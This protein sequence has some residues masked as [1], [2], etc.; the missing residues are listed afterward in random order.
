L[1]T[2]YSRHYNNNSYLITM[3]SKKSNLPSGFKC[4]GN[5]KEGHNCQIY[6]VA[7]SDDL[8]QQHSG[9]AD[10]PL[11]Q[12]FATCGGNTVSVY[13]VHDRQKPRIVLRQGYI[14]AHDDEVFYACAFGGRSL[15]RPFGYGPVNNTNDEKPGDVIVLGSTDE[16]DQDR[17]R[18]REEEEPSSTATPTASSSK[19]TT[20]KQTKSSGATMDTDKL[21]QDMIDTDQ[22]DGPQLLCV[23][24][25]GATVK[26]I[27]VCRRMLYTTLSGHGDDIYDLKFS[28][29][30]EWIL[31]SASKDE[32]LRMWNIKTSTC[33]AIFS[34]HEGHRDCVLSVAWHPHGNKFASGGMDTTVKLWDVGE[35]GSSGVRD[36]IARSKTVKP[37]RLDQRVDPESKFLLIYEQMPIFSTDKVHT[38]YVDGIQFVGDLILSKDTNDKVLLWKPVT[39]K[40]SRGSN[41][42]TQQRLPNE[43]IVLREFTLSK[44]DVWFVRFATDHKCRMLALGNNAGEIKVW[45]IRSRPSD[46]H[47][48]NL[49]HQY[50]SSAVRM[51]AFNHDDKYLV[52]VTD[53][54]SVLLW[55]ATMKK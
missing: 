4:V 15:G 44:C 42:K 54:S 38:D 24:G 16:E 30:D 35:E 53:D 49:T 48:L 10:S 52:A 29:T 27:D 45:E 23:A 2:K 46:S 51:V 19:D 9:D 17:K 41:T 25:T 37:K 21:Y 43:V 39:T 13:E 7:W 36:A 3:P 26:V 12:C 14:D 50:G 33:V 32:S 8:Y 5:A 18:P 6:C 11:L 40:T 34:G 47:F 31:L 55:E 1:S 20:E 28:P 22:F